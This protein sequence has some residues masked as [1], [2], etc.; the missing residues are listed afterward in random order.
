MVTLNAHGTNVGESEKVQSFL[1][2]RYICNEIV[3]VVCDFM[4]CVTGFETKVDAN[5]NKVSRSRS[6]STLRSSGNS[7]A[8]YVW[9]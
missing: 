6:K 8:S 7:L 9:L 3:L 5:A 4:L 2:H 1:F